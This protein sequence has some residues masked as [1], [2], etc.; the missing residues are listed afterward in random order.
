MKATIF[1]ANIEAYVEALQRKGEYEISNAT[2]KKVPDQYASRENEYSM[3]VNKAAKIIT[4]TPDPAV[5]GPCYQTIASV[6]HNI[7][8]VLLGNTLSH[9]HIFIILHVN[10]CF[11]L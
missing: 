4:L 6:P 10:I 5:L 9:N 2:I 1:G 8:N 7:D 3:T 11:Q